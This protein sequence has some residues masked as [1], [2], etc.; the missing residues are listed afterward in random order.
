MRHRFMLFSLYG[1]AHMPWLFCMCL[2]MAVDTLH[3]LW[4]DQ[5]RNEIAASV[6]INAPEITLTVAPGSVVMPIVVY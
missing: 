3:G 4:Q 2:G 1:M 6:G 5:I